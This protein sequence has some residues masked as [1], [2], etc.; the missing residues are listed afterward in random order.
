MSDIKVDKL[1]ARNY[2]TWKL[3]MASLLKSRGL[4]D[5]VQE[6]QV[7]N[8]ENKDTERDENEELDKLKDEDLKTMMRNEE[9][10]HLMYATMDAYQIASTGSCYNAHELW[11]KIQQNHEGAEENL[12]NNAL[13]DFLGF[14]HNKGESLVTYELTLARL[15]AVGQTIDEATKLW[16]FRH[17]LPKEL[18]SD[19]NTWSLAR[20]DGSISELITHLKILHHMEKSEGDRESAALFAGGQPQ[21]ASSGTNNKVSLFCTYCKLTNHIWKDCRKLQADKNRKKAYA[22]GNNNSRNSNSNRNSNNNRNNR[23]NSNNYQR[24]QNNSRNSNSNRNNNNNDRNQRVNNNTTNNNNNR[25][26]EAYM[27]SVSGPTIHNMNVWVVDSGATSHMT[28]HKSLLFDYHKFETPH[29]VYLGDGKRH[30]APGFGRV[31]FTCNNRSGHLTEVLWIPQL[32]ENLFSVCTN[33]NQGY[34]IKFQCQPPEVHFIKN[35]EIKLTGSGSGRGLFTLI[36]EPVVNLGASPDQA[37]VGASEEEW[38][39]R[40]AHASNARIRN[41]ISNE[42]VLGLNIDNN[43]KSRC[44]CCAAGKLC[45]S[46]HPTSKHNQGDENSATLNIDTVGPMSLSVGGS[47][48]FVLATEGYSGYMLI[49]FITSKT[50]VPSSVKRMINSVELNSRRLVKRL[51]TD[52]G[53]EYVNHELKSWLDLKGIVHDT[54]CPQTPEQNGMSE[55]SNRTIIE[56]ARTLLS[57]ANLPEELWTHA[58][59]TVV[60]ATNRTISPR[61]P[62]HKRTRFEMYHGYKPDVSNLRIFG[63]FALTYVHNKRSKWAEKGER[64]RFIGYTERSNTYKFYSLENYRVFRSCDVVFLK[65]DI[66]DTQ[67]EKPVDQPEIATIRHQPAIKRPCLTNNGNKKNTVNNLSNLQDNLD[68]NTPNNHTLDT[69]TTEIIDQNE[70]SSDDSVHWLSADE[71]PCRTKRTVNRRT[72]RSRTAE[73][74]SELTLPKDAVKWGWGIEPNDSPIQRALF[75]LDDEPRTLNDAKSSPEW[76]NWQKAIDEEMQALNKNKTWILVDRPPNTKLVKNK[77]VFKVKLDPQGK[78]ERFKARLVAK[79]YS[80]IENVDYKETYAP[81]ASM[82]TIRIL[83]AVANQRRMQILQFDVKTAFL[84]GDLDETIYMEYPDGLPNPKNKVCKLI[85]SLYGLKQ[86]PRQWNKKF[87]DFL[88]RFNLQQSKIDKCMYFNNDRT[89]LIAIYV[90]DGL[91]AS[92]DPKLLT[93]LVNYLRDQ[94]ELKVMECEA[95]LGFQVSRDKENG[96]LF[97]HQSHYATKILEK[98]NMADCNPT[99]TPEEVKQTDTDGKELGPEYPFKELVGSLLYLTTCTRPDIAHAVSMA[100]RTSK[101]TTEHWMRL[102]RILRYLKGTLNQGI[103]FRW[104]DSPELVGYS[105]ANYAMDE[106]T[107]RSTTGYTVMY[108]GAPIAW[109]C[110]RQPIVTLSTAEAEYVSGCELVKELLPIRQL[111]IEIGEI[112]NKPVTIFID[113]QSTI[114]MAKD[115]GSQQRTKHI[116]VR[117]KWLNEQHDKGT[118]AVQHVPGESQ[119]ADILTKPLHKTKFAKNRDLLVSTLV[120]LS[121]VTAVTAKHFNFQEISPV[122]FKSTPYVKIEGYTDYEL[123]VVFVNPC[124]RFFNNLTTS[125]KDNDLL[126]R[127]CLTKLNQIYNMN[128]HYCKGPRDVWKYTPEE[129]RTMVLNGS[130]TTDYKRD[131]RNPGVLIVVGT[132]VWGAGQIYDYTAQETNAENIAILHQA[133]IERDKFLNASLQYLTALRN[134]NTR[135]VENLYRMDVRLTNL[136]TRVDNFPTI[137]FLINEYDNLFERIKTMISLIDQ[138]ARSGKVSPA[139]A[140]LTK[141]PLWEE[142]ASEWSTL[143]ACQVTFDP[144]DVDLNLKLKYHFRLPIRE[145]EINFFKAQ[146]F[147]FWNETKNGGEVQHCKME[148]NG[149]KIIMQ[150]VSSNCFYATHETINDIEERGGYVDAHYT[151]D[152]EGGTAGIDGSAFTKTVCLA[153]RP[154]ITTNQWIDFNGFHHIQCDG[155]MITIDGND[156]KCPKYAFRI[157]NTHT[158]N[159]TD[160]R[161]YGHKFARTYVNR[162]EIEFSN[163]LL[164]Q[165]SVEHVDIHRINDTEVQNAY[166]RLVSSF[167][168]IKQNITMKKIELPDVIK[169]PIAWVRTWSNW[170]WD[171][172]EKGVIVIIGL[173]ILIALILAAPLI[174]VLFIVLRGVFIFGSRFSGTLY[175]LREMMKHH[176]NK[177]KAK[178]SHKVQLLKAEVKHQKQKVRQSARIRNGYMKMV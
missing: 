117:E 104:E 27:A 95:Y 140:K 155:A 91:V 84:H 80:Q 89:L 119:I 20:P 14:R 15:S 6:D 152:K 132:V 8:D 61:D 148:Y 16:V 24:N 37:L 21:L 113:N 93:N 106:E 101:P 163:D 110:Q 38:H 30:E 83:F 116:D 114:K 144:H 131:R 87:D 134:Q 13:A 135:I 63:Q 177:F 125:T 102:K 111:M 99:S 29:P 85:K 79:G 52:N 68:G 129:A 166:T 50:E 133:I 33:L 23:Q 69:S 137:A 53:T 42:A 76:P 159:L 81:V 19:C 46:S 22:T 94:F 147:S 153:K 143:N 128:V 174:E 64:C 86:A 77:W 151:C 172:V 123:E 168:D 60:Y 161:Y 120:L 138:A 4:W 26:S 156:Y 82:N 57:D 173:G 154:P 18:K 165:L 40:F 55:R 158:F 107:R 126:E 97:L 7:W 136:E 178:T 139:A 17:T 169:K 103:L 36:L 49:S 66:K 150:N 35:N 171:M 78:I 3:V 54:S 175:S 47:T 41:L 70:I 122:I 142:P 9:A 92:S 31:K 74:K 145:K 118:I 72:T 59:D 12:R 28:P 51:L 62:E 11:T 130:V 71:S 162:M 56:G 112:E 170:F 127:N 108:C 67:I 121:L 45:R 44:A 115:E 160:Y 90:D 88:K 98:F 167:N 149:P 2:T 73:G 58:A 34:D 10:K 157:P 75:T 65:D 96:T 32:K 146:A 1:N 48:Y 43:T 100:S 39:R 176:F 164:R 105:D 141:D 109:R 5:T 124:Y 25:Y